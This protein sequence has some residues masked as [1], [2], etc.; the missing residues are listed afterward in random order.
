[1]NL[2]LL[3]PLAVLAVCSAQV[4]RKDTT[5]LG[6]VPMTF[7]DAMRYCQ[8]RKKRMAT[9]LSVEDNLHFLKKL[10]VLGSHRM[11]I[12]VHRLE[13][14]DDVPPYSWTI[15]KLLQTQVPNEFW[16]P[17]EPNN[18]QNHTERCV[19]MRDLEKNK[20]TAT[21]NDAPCKRKNAFFC[22]VL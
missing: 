22:D 10:K 5:T 19:E 21:W 3:V 14:K 2:Y 8:A 18:Y 1:M 16:G 9:P 6:T 7:K 15:H 17:N 12:G 13:D 11:W 4:P 20:E